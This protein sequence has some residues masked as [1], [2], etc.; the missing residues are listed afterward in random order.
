MEKYQWQISIPIFR[1]SIILRQL[2]LAVGIPF[3]LVI[4]I[5]IFFSGINRYTL[6][7]LILI[8]ATLALSWL[9]IMIVYGGRYDVEFLLDQR[10]AHSQT[11]ENQRKK[12]RLINRLTIIAGLIS[13]KPAV[14]GAGLLAQSRQAESIK[15]TEVRTVKYD[16]RRK[17]ILLSGG[18]TKKMVLFCERDNYESVSGA[19]KT[20]LNGKG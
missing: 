8:S 6:Y 16:S 5:L 12:N 14:A 11:Q 15:W 2:A 20:F 4:A 13:G 10:G 1:N 9:F 3:G 17:T 7:A 19:V 18:W